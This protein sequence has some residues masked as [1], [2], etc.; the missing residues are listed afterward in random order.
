MGAAFGEKVEALSL[1]TVTDRGF[2]W[3]GDC[4]GT[5]GQPGGTSGVGRRRVGAPGQQ[6]VIGVRLV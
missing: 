2:I 4:H 6:P 5:S 3:V 1:P